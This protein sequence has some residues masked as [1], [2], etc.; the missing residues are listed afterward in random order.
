MQESLF[1]PCNADVHRFM[2]H[3]DEKQM[4]TVFH[5]IQAHLATSLLLN[6][7]VQVLSAGWEETS[8]NIH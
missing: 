4:S 7:G 2:T 1:C 5:I 3:R 6:V 8:R